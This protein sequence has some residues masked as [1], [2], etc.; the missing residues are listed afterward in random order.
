MA[1]S[2]R[3]H[4][5]TRSG[6]D[7]PLR[8]VLSG[9]PSR[10]AIPRM[11]RR[12]R[13]RSRHAAKTSGASLA[14]SGR[15]TRPLAGTVAE[16]YLEARGVGHI[17]G[18]PALRFHP[19][20]SHP[21]VPGRF[22]C[23]VAGV[24]DAGGRFLPASSGPTS[25]WTAPAR[26]MS[27]R[28]ALHSGRSPA[29]RCGSPNPAMTGCSSARVSRARQQRRSF[30]T[31]AAAHGQRSGLPGLRAVEP[32]EHV[33]HVTIAADRDAKGGGQLAGGGGA[34]PKVGRRPK[35]RRVELRALR[36]RLVRRRSTG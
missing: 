30:S 28:Y 9:T 18:A 34:R 6:P 13:Q 4:R 10:R 35:G 33:R 19:G 31:G 25:R 8:A 36:R 20:L 32:P 11:R 14:E 22:P 2:G 3:V 15:Q 1:R 29:A 17:A 26:P 27:I 5:A 7:E 12:M 21:S 23:L 16:R 24:Q